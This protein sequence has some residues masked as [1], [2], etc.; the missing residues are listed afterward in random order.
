MPWKS[1]HVA[2]TMIN[3]CIMNFIHRWS[4][5]GGGCAQVS[6]LWVWHQSASCTFRLY[7]VLEDKCLSD[8]RMVLGWHFGW[9][10]LETGWCIT[11]LFVSQPCLGSLDLACERGG[12]G[13]RLMFWSD[14]K[15]F[16]VWLLPCRFWGLWTRLTAY[17]NYTDHLVVASF[18]LQD[19]WGGHFRIVHTP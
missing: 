7:L 3:T 19:L 1:I 10:R 12:R 18:H 17:A 5:F 11:C 8:G 2:V 16:Q 4:W 13:Q 9:T 6:F 14:S 15:H